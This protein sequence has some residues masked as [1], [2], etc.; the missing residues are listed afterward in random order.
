MSLQTQYQKKLTIARWTLF[1]QKKNAA[2]SGKINLMDVNKSEITD[3]PAIEES[4]ETLYYVNKSKTLQTKGQKKY[5][6]KFTRKKKKQK[7]K[8]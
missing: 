7:T 4:P 6:G 2:E 8:W 3:Q 1:W 5:V